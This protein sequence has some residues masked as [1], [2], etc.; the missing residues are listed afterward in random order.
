MSKEKVRHKAHFVAASKGKPG[1]FATQVD[2]Y[3]VVP[4]EITPAFHPMRH[5][6]PDNKQS[7]D[8]AHIYHVYHRPAGSEPWD[9]SKHIQVHG[10]KKEAENHVSKL[11]D[12]HAIGVKA[13]ATRKRHG[14]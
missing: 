1:T 9:S 12:N 10:S 4:E 14:K 7:K 11:R 8:T 2:E 13:A 6:L 5:L 3:K